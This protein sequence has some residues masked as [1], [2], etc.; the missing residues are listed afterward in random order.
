M[1]SVLK[2]ERPALSVALRPGGRHQVTRPSIF[3][4]LDIL[5]AG[6]NP[7]VNRAVWPG[8][9]RRWR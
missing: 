2:F 1:N 8:P 5:L 7:V 6:I 9:F 3:A 4:V